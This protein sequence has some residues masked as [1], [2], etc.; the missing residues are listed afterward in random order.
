MRPIAVGEVLRRLVAKVAFKKVLPPTQ[1]GVGM[2]DAV[3]HVALAVRCSH[4]TCLAD[5]DS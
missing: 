4:G 5:P 1:T 2:K 3:A